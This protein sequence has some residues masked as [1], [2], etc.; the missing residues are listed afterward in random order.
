MLQDKFIDTLRTA[1]TASVT[2][3]ALCGCSLIKEDLPECPARLSL[4]FVYDYN[5]LMTDAFPSQVKSVNVWAFDHTGAFVWSGSASGP[6]LSERGFVMETPLAEGTYNFIAWCG[7]E[8]NADFTLA[9]YTPSSKEDLELKLNTIT[10]DGLNVSSS[11]FHP[12]FHGMV[13]DFTYTVNSTEPSLATVTIPLMKDTNDIAVMLQ[14]EDGTPLDK[15]D[16]SVT[17]TYADADLEWDNAIT[18]DSPTVT[19]RPW[20]TL[21]G[22][23]TTIENA[24]PGQPV[25]STLLYEMSVSR[26]MVDGNAY[27]DVVRNEDQV[28]IIHI[29]LIKFFL[30]EKG[31][32]FDHFGEQEYLDRR[33]DYSALFFLDSN[34]NWYTAAGIYINGWALVPPQS[35]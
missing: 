21:Y 25:V 30:L 9:T 23:T 12:L 10:I 24:A 3:A 22:E 19:Y 2:A 35:N 34:K 4:Q 6:A 32:R 8:G 1:V 16:F 27:L 31:S 15:N 7:L 5:L 28:T 20:S 26:L 13:S 11:H 17:F 18:P 33:S 29:P 14:N